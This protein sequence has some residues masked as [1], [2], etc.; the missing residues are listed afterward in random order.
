MTRPRQ[1]ADT[2]SLTAT[3]PRQFVHRAALAETFLTGWRRTGTDRFT[4]YAQWPRA[5]GLHVSPDWCSYDPLLVVETVRQAGTLIMHTEYGVPLDRQFV[6]NAFEVTT[7]PHRLE[8]GPVPAEPTVE[9]AFT[10]VRYRGSQPAACRYSARVL[11][12]GERA[13]TADVSF[14]CVGEAVYRRLRGG[15]TPGAVTAVPLPPGLPPQV[16]D[17]ALP[18]DVVLALPGLDPRA[19]GGRWQLRVNTAHPVF[20]DHPLDHVPGMLLLEAAR[21]AARFALPGTYAPSAYRAVFRRYAELDE[22]VWI[23]ARD[24]GGGHLQVVGVQRESAVFECGVD[25]AAG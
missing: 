19:P 3:V 10:D 23:E 15:R 9:L 18:A 11:C 16:V 21:Q 8:V 5:H 22:P 13:A 7:D 14:T 17:R 6:L 2:P 4:V 24:E 25:A 20:F 12:R 1:S